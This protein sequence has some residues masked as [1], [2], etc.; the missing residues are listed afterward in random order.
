MIIQMLEKP[1]HIP[2]MLKEILEISSAVISQSPKPRYFDGTL[3][4]GGHLLELMKAHPNLTAVAFDR[5]QQALS[6][7]REQIGKPQNISLIHK[8]FHDFRADQQELFDVMLLD[9]GVSSPQL[10][11]A[12]RGFS[13]MQDG[14]LDMR[15]DQSAELTAAQLLRDCDEDELVQIFQKYGEIRK[16]FRVVRAI[17]HDRKEKEF[18]STIELAEMIARIEGWRKKGFHPATQ[19]FMAL[20]IA[21]NDELRGLE[22]ALEHLAAGLKSNGRLL[23]LTF[24]SLEDRIVKWSF[25]E[26]LQLL[27]EPLFKRV[28]EPSPEEEKANPRSRSAKLRVFVRK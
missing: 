12:D 18:N 24:H 6:E 15:M 23:I 2:V 10:D 20:R 11:Q 19:Y 25:K 17:V 9:L 14:P 21:V 1:K 3:G 16:P 7:V 26:H 5:D 28:L 8:S 22:A 27:G 13:F 4:R